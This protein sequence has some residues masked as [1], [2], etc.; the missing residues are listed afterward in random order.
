MEITEIRVD[1]R[2]IRDSAQVHTGF[3][4]VL[5]SPVEPQAIKYQ[6]VC[7][8]LDKVFQLNQVA[9]VQLRQGA[10]DLEPDETVVIRPVHENDRSDV[11]LEIEFDLGHHVVGGRAV[12][13]WSAR[14]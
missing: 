4:F 14:K 1:D 3:G 8:T 2:S 11:G 9:Q 5:R 10:R 6:V 13:I 12:K 7:R